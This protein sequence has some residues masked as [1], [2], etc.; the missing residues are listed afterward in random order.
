MIIAPS[1]DEGRM[2][3]AIRIQDSHGQPWRLLRK[4][5]NRP[6]AFKTASERDVFMNELR[7][8]CESMSA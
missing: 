4:S 2:P 6:V 7:I 3:Y 8:D 5:G 1:I